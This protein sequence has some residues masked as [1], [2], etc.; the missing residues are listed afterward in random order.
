VGLRRPFSFPNIL[1]RRPRTVNYNVQQN[2]RII[3]YFRLSVV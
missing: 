2:Q 3:A 1:G